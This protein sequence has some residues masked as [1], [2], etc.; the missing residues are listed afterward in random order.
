MDL[1]NFKWRVWAVKQLTA[2]ALLLLPYLVV[3]IKNPEI[4]TWVDNNVPI[5][6]AI[7]VAWVTRSDINSLSTQN[8]VAK[9]VAKKVLKEKESP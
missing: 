1:S 5:V 7:V 4:A 3:K 8:A 6:L 2:L 9:N